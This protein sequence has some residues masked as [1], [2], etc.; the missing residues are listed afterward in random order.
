MG[1]DHDRE[2]GARPP[3]EDTQPIVSDRSGGRASMG[4]IAHPPSGRVESTEPSFPSP[5]PGPVAPSVEASEAPGGPRPP[6]K[7]AKG[8]VE[9]GPSII[10][11]DTPL[12]AAR[13][14]S[15]GRNDSIDELM[16]GFAEPVLPSKRKATKPTPRPP[17]VEI[18]APTLDRPRPVAAAR[19]AATVVTPEGGALRER[20]RLLALVGVGVALG[21]AFFGYRALTAPPASTRGSTLAV[22]TV[23]TASVTAASTGAAAPPSQPTGALVPPTATFASAAPVA[24]PSSSAS[25]HVSPREIHRA[26]PA[27]SSTTTAVAPSPSSHNPDN[28]FLEEKRK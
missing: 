25:A 4:V 12:E 16:Q 11:A 15:L 24:A 1:S 9:Q 2:L 26:A 13:A 27:T 7:D 19:G 20:R 28:A 17:E 21:I 22:P 14:R 10:V 23:D 3:R 18:D 8:T 6:A 5:P